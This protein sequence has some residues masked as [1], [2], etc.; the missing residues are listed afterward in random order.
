MTNSYN[1]VFKAGSFQKLGLVAL[2]LSGAAVAAQAQTLNYAPATATNV[3]GTYTDLAA[4][5]TAIAT[6]NTDDA[7]SAAQPIGFTFTFNGTAFTEFVLNT[8]GFIKLGATAPSVANLYYR[9]EVTIAGDPFTSTNAADVNIVSPF[10]VDLQSGTGTAEY[11]VSTT[12]TAGSRVCTIQWKNVKDK[13]L[14]KAAQYDNFSFQAKLYESTNIIEFVYGPTV[15][16]TTGA[17]DFRFAAVGIKG[18]GSGAG[19]TVLANKPGSLAAW[20]T[21]VFITGSYSSSAHNYRRSVPAD[22]GRTYRFAPT[23]NNDAAVRAIYTLGKIATPAALPQTVRA[24]ITNTGLAAKTN[25]DVT[26]NISGANTFTDTKRVASLA[27]GASTLVT[28]T[29]LPATLALGTNSVTVTLP[30][31]DIASNNT[32]TVSQLVTSD[33]LSYIEPGRATNGAFSGFA[34][35]T[36]AFA[37]KYA[38]SGTVVLTEEVLTFAALNPASTV[39]FQAVVYDA[40][41]SG[42]LPGKLLYTSPTQNR[43]AASGTVTVA[44]PSLQVT[45]AFYLGVVEAGT[46]GIGIATQSETPIRASTFYFSADGA[47]SWTDFTTQTSAGRLAIE[48]GLAPAP[49]CAPPT[50]LAVT[51]STPTTATVTFADA[52]NTG[53][54]QLIYGLVGFQPAT[55]G[56]TVTATASPFTLTGLQPGTNYQVYVRTN[57]S[58]GG[59]SLLTGP[60]N[61]GTPCATVTSVATFPYTENF[62]N[63]PAGLALPCGYTILNANNDGATWAV[64][65]TNPN[66]GANTIRYRGF[67]LNNVAADDWFFTPALT[68]AATS[69]YQVAFRYRG[70][71]ITNSPSTFTESLEVTSGTAATVAAQTNVLYT[72]AA[73]TNT[74]YALANGAS[75][76]AVALLP[77]GASIQYVGF[78]IKSAAN[79]GNLYIDDIA[80]TATAVTANS[81]AL[82]RAISVFPNPSTTGLFDLEIHGA[83]AKGRLGVLVTNTLSQQVYTGSARDNYNNKLDLSSLAPGIYYLQVRNGDEQ[84]TSRVSIVK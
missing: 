84:M 31:D 3:A 80:I 2:L 69:R 1:Q 28:F 50:A 40:S 47:T 45:D 42:G 56:T 24:V 18:A 48:A 30:A 60:I 63:L 66:S 54:Y 72:N 23:P 53:S 68:L 67:T 8:N 65:N 29:A 64:T 75:T 11:R 46:T 15:A 7:N 27:A 36:T 43:P 35:S 38:V 76:P 74:S 82:L 61:V 6:A 79:Q 39:A 71:G 62:D 4:T 70:E 9:T 59:T 55:S 19:Q 78:H 41:G 73:I 37:V 5:G 77:A 12:G 22:A 58:A 20:S 16:A 14:T 25:L 83:N 34:N 49:N 33:R 32:S 52:S 26:L 13:A 51:S 81:E 57:C 10:N 21:T 44:L 17:E